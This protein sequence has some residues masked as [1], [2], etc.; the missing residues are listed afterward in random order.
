MPR[1]RATQHCLD[2]KMHYQAP[3]PRSAHWCCEIGAKVRYQRVRTSPDWCPKG[4][5]LAGVPYPTFA[6]GAEKEP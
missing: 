2:C 6:P 1:H 3:W 5:R 4:H